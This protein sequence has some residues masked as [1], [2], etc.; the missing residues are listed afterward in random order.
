MKAAAYQLYE[1]MPTP[2]AWRGPE[3][4]VVTITLTGSGVIDGM[5]Q[6]VP[7]I[8]VSAAMGFYLQ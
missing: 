5:L 3:N 6:A 4:G 7:E 8:E 1:E 2:I